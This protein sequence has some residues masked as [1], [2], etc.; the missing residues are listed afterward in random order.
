MTV[1]RSLLLPVLRVLLFGA[2]ADRIVADALSQAA[3]GVFQA[4]PGHSSASAAAPA[5]EACPGSLQRLLRVVMWGAASLTHAELAEAASQILQLAGQS[6]DD[7]T[8][9]QLSQHIRQ[10]SKCVNLS[11]LVRELLNCIS[12]LGTF[13]RSRKRLGRSALRFHNCRDPMRHATRQ[14]TAAVAMGYFKRVFLMSLDEQHCL[15]RA[16]AGM[17]AQEI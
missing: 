10:V 17:T 4:L 12:C 5:A 15:V 8:I 13:S 3:L 7:V 9:N 11:Q 6:T 14:S 1:G 2:P 16:M